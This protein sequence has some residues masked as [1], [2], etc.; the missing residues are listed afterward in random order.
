MRHARVDDPWPALPRR[1]SFVLPQD[2]EHI[3]RFNETAAPSHRVRLEL[4]PEPFLGNPRAPVVLLGLN[5]G[6]NSAD[7]K[8][9]HGDPYF[10]ASL[11]RSLAH[12]ATKYANYLLDPHSADAPG[13][14]WWRRRLRQPIHDFGLEVIARW[15]FVL[16]LFPYHSKQFG[17]AVAWS[18]APRVRRRGPRHGRRSLRVRP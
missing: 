8:Y 1:P 15:V 11:R 16:E 4:L 17:R 6:F 5:P 12:E 7:A 14:R 13:G 10:I 9:H 2:E 18:R 3:R